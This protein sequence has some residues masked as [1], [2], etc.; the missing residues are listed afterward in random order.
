[1]GCVLSYRFVA[2]FLLYFSREF[3]YHWQR[4]PLETRGSIRAAL[5]KVLLA[6]FAPAG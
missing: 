1:M 6:I 3:S 5:N 2:V 4:I